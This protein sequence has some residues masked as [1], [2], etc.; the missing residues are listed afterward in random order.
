[1]SLRVN[2]ITPTEK[3]SGSRINARTFIHIGEFVVPA[4]IIFAIGKLALGLIMASSQ[5]QALESRWKLAQPRE[6]RAKKLAGTLNYNR[7]TEAELKNWKQSSIRLN[8]QLHAVSD[9]TPATIQLISVI[10][11]RELVQEE[12]KKGKKQKKGIPK[13]RFTITIDGKTS[14]E[15]A[16]DQIE[17]FKEKLTHHNFISNI[18]ES[19]EVTNYEADT[20]DN[21]GE[22]DR[23]FQIECIYKLLPEDKKK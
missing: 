2:L 3:R 16:M 22:L 9:S 11:S 15:N 4:I 13:T 21:A 18:I 23:I 10:L 12:K 8:K 5:M 14:D 17:I 20:S 1:M 19:V 6:A 7:K